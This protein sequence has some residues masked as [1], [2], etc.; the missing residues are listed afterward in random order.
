MTAGPLSKQQNAFAKI[1]KR[2]FM[3]GAIPALTGQQGHVKPL[4]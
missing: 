2:P 4:P 3:Q 1:S